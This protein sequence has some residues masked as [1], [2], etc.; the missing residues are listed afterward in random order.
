ME[1]TKVQYATVVGCWDTEKCQRAFFKCIYYHLSHNFHLG[2]KKTISE[3]GFP[4]TCVFIISRAKSSLYVRVKYQDESV[5]AHIITKKACGN[6]VAKYIKLLL[7][8]GSCHGNF[9]FHY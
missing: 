1:D 6:W 3:D 9:W 2:E 7:F 4:N 8:P 5:F